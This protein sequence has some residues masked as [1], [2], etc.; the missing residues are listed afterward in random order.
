MAFLRGNTIPDRR[1]HLQQ[2]M[3]DRKFEVEEQQLHGETDRLSREIYGLQDRVRQLEQQLDTITSKL[4]NPQFQA[5]WPQLEQEKTN[6]E[7]QLERLT[8]VEIGEARELEKDLIRF[9]ELV[10]KEEK[11]DK[12]FA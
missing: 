8:N 9:G 3:V 5:Q 11:F 1:K 12:S 6:V 7:Q 2:I 10:K 4:G